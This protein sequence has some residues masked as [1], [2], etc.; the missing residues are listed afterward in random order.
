MRDASD[1]LYLL[2]LEREVGGH[3]GAPVQPHHAGHEERR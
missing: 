3:H 2:D 1:P